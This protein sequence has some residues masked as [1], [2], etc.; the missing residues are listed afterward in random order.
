[1]IEVV[2]IQAHMDKIA[3]LTKEVDKTDGW[4]EL[5]NEGGAAGYTK[6]LEDGDT[7]LRV[8]CELDI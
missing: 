4:E 5:I 3:M 2:D 6:K 7:A 1:M 8:T